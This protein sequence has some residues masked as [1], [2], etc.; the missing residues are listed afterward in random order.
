MVT[1]TVEQEAVLSI[2]GPLGPLWSVSFSRTIPTVNNINL[3]N[4]TL[5]NWSVIVPMVVLLASRLMTR[6]KK[7]EALPVPERVADL[8]RQRAPPAYSVN[9]QSN[10]KWYKV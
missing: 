9:V 8:T 7:V 5:R 4:T 1:L 3:M 10:M 6:T 2:V